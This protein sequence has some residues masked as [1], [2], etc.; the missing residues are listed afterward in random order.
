MDITCK[1]DC[2]RRVILVAALIAVMLTLS[3]FI[4]HVEVAFAQSPSVNNESDRITNARA[5]INR[6]A[7][8]EAI[9]DLSEAVRSYGAEGNYRQQ[10]KASIL[11]GYAYQ[12]IGHYNEAQKSLESA[13]A[14]AQKQGKERDMASIYAGLGDVYGV[15]GQSEKALEYLNGGLALAEKENDQLLASSILNNIGNLHTK[16][17]NYS[18]A[19]KAYEGS[20]E[21]SKGTKETMLFSRTLSNTAIVSAKAGRN[22]NAREY[23][24]KGVISIGS[25]DDSHEKILIMTNLGIAAL[26]LYRQVVP[27]DG[28]LLTLAQKTLDNAMA[29]AERI[30][31]PLGESYAAGYLGSTYEEAGQNEKALGLTRQA[32]LQ[33][34]KYTP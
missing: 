26:T 31:D 20:I 29:I 5:L 28:S 24:D 11:M 34:K 2:M 12:S 10:V 21:R 1:E 23:V 8:Q 22:E 9:S 6:G 3:L 13:M 16:N 30:K 18:E 17:K 14:I 4:D 27:K 32:V 7:Y 15:S 33:R 19:I 25:V